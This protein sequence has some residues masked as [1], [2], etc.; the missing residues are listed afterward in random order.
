MKSVT[1]DN[2]K[3]F[4][5]AYPNHAGELDRLEKVINRI[6]DPELR[7][8]VSARVNVEL[9]IVFLKNQEV[10]TALHH[11]FEEQLSDLSEFAN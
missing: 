10:L 1:P 6:E 8:K 11:I 7:E 2:F 5:E 4:R 9:G 3:R